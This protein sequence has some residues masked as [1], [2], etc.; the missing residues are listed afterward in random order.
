MFQGRIHLLEAA[1]CLPKPAAEKRNENPPE[2]LTLHEKCSAVSRMKL[3]VVL[4]VEDAGE[5]E[6]TEPGKIRGSR[7]PFGRVA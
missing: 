6:V 3:Q 4:T 1:P 5:D 7:P 2:L